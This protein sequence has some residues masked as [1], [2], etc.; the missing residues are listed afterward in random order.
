MTSAKR[1]STTRGV[2]PSA[3]KEN[4]AVMPS[5]DPAEPQIWCYS[6]QMSYA[7]GELIQL[8]VSTSA[9]AYDLVIVRDG[10]TA[11]TV[12]ERSGLDGRLHPVAED[13]SVTGCRWPVALEVPVAESWRSGGYIVRL[14]ARFAD[15]TTMEGHHVVIVRAGTTAAPI[16]QVAATSTWI[17]Y[18]DWGGSNHYEGITGTARNL[19]SPYLSTQR[20]WTRGFAFLPIGAPRVPIREPLRQGAAPRYPHM[21]WAYANGYSKKYASAGW[22]SYDRHFCRWAEAQGFEVDL[23][24]LHDL[25]F[26][27]D[28]LKRYKLVVFVGHDEYWT[29]EMRDAV[30]RY[31]EGG[32][33]VAR[34]AGN[35]LWQVRFEDE[36]RTQVCYK[37]RARKED[38][39][40]KDPARR[41]LTTN[42]W[43]AP[44]VGRPGTETFGLNSLRGVYVGWGGCVPRG[45][46][47]FTIYRPEHWAFEGSDLYYGDVLGGQSKI[48][49]Y[50][51]DGLDYTFRDGLPFPT[52]TAGAPEGLQILAMGHASIL[53]ENHANPG[54]DLF[55]GDEDLV[56][57][58]ETLFGAATPEAMDK[59]RR[60]SGMIVTF[61]K[62][63]GEIFHAGTCE[64][65]A[66]LIDRD[67]YVERVTRNVIERYLG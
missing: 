23:A 25:H 37:Y 30:D 42:A 40:V 53:E 28:I 29:G 31:V 45:P 38:P 36:G 5:A 48:F 20:P 8:H 14:T 46:G 16:L 12:F 11:T 6:D 32:G 55:I 52:E 43:E 59:L 1:G 15:G 4:F 19:F 18:N 44:E 9:P 26:D 47:G 54:S 22:A 64:W 2:W 13:V 35:F 57:A 3:I 34:F 51:V 56:F 17:A 65:V 50:E 62:G 61:P 63:K 27:P 24:T 21:E 49:G 66:G 41:H 58:A 39:Y 60:S 67:P 7:P 10:S 33:R